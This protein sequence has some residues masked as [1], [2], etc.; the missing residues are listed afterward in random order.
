MKAEENPFA[1]RPNERRQA[2]DAIEQMETFGQQLRQM[3]FQ[4]E[5]PVEQAATRIEKQCGGIVNNLTGQD[6]AD[7]LRALPAIMRSISRNLAE[8]VKCQR[9]FWGIDMKPNGKRAKAKA[10]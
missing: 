3:S 5:P 9:E 6:L 7:Q 1:I 10:R 8:E 2:A 4:L